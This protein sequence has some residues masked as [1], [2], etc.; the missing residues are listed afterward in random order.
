MMNVILNDGLQDEGFI[1]AHTVGPFLVRSDN[2]RFLKERDVVASGTDRFMAWDV[3]TNQAL[4]CDSLHSSPS[5]SGVYHVNGIECRP[6]FQLLAELITQYPPAKAAEITGVPADTIERLA[7][8]YVTNKPA[9]IHTDN[10]LGRTYHGDLTYRAVFTLATMAGNITL[11]NQA[12]HRDVVLKWDP[13]LQADPHK[14][15]SL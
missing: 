14:S 10:G 2:G 11:P 13:F 8:A 15:Y 7:R 12:G 3:A 5:L 6:S 9:N 1:R 4:P